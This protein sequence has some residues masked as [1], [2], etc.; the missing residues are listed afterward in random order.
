MHPQKDSK[1]GRTIKRLEKSEGFFGKT[2]TPS[3]TYRTRG[4]NTKPIY[5]D[6]DTEDHSSVIEEVVKVHDPN[7]MAQSR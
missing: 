6:S 4:S 3:P 5:L 7:H 1:R 2:P